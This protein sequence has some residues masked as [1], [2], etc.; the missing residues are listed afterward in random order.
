METTLVLLNAITKKI[1]HPLDICFHLQFT[2][3]PDET[4]MSEWHQVQQKGWHRVRVSGQWCLP[5]EEV[6]G[7]TAPLGDL[8][9]F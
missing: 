5:R 8:G 2:G 9:C 7:R 6:L 4:D 1:F 3:L